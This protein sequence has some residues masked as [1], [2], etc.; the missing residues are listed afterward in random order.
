M[1]RL[2]R[3][4]ANVQ[5]KLALDRFI[6]G[7]A[8]ASV[9][10]AGAVWLTIIVDRV[11]RVRPP[12]WHMWFWAG[13]GVTL[14]AA[15]AYAILRRP[16]PHAAA[17]A[18]DQKLGLKEKISTALFV[19]PSTE[20]PFAAAA[21]RDAETTAER[22]SIDYRRLFPFRFPRPAVATVIIGALALWTL[23][24]KP[25]D[26]FGKEEQRKQ[27][28]QQQAK[29][30]DARR[31]I[32]RAIATV[33]AIPKAVANEEAIR[34]AKTELVNLKASGIKDPEQAKRSAAKALQDVNEA[35]KNKINNS[36]EFADARQQDRLLK[37]LQ[38]P[39]PGEGPIADAHN[40]MVK[41]DFANAIAQM[42][43]AIEKF[44]KMDAES[45]KK[46]SQQMQ[47]LAQAMQKMANDPQAQQQMQQQLQQM[48][49][50]QKQAQQAQQLMQQA[51]Q[52]DKQAQQ[53]LQ[54]MAQQ[55]MQQM[56]NGQGPNQQQQQ[57]IQQMMQQMQAMANNQQVAQQMQQAA[58]Q[59]AKAMQQQQQQQGQQGMQQQAQGQQGQQANQ[60]QQQGA[61]QQ[62]MQQ[63]MQAMRQQLQQMQAI[64][65]D[66]Q[67]M[68]AAQGQAAGAQAAAQDALNGGNP[69]GQNPGGGQWDMNGNIQGN[70]Q[71]G[72]WDG[73]ARPAGPNPGGIGAGDRTYKQQAPFTV[74]Q[75]V[76]QSQDD[77]KGKI[78]AS[79]FVKDSKP[80]K[81]DS[82]VTLKDVAA[83][84]QA[85]QTDEVD[86]ERISPQ[87][88]KAV[89]EYFSSMERE[90][91]PATQ[92]AR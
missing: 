29:V 37:Q 70:G 87:A 23:T 74:K 1:N 7:L 50:N 83:A 76:S 43:D 3:H 11:L 35:L 22:V 80:I 91:T 56:N 9:A 27:E 25:L 18:I 4:V 54:Q 32:D 84:A 90:T 41:G 16:S 46:A 69:G 42:E 40:S 13:L 34:L 6:A 2:D 21:V 81:G 14:V 85:E 48:G 30:E 59:M 8:W 62:G 66:A 68:A 44:D 12:A 17:V 58:Q 57:Q 64:A 52:G 71:E 75:E 65:G 78:L 36:Q 5:N 20:D 45:Q 82:K 53:Q 28:L 79:S 67:Q 61:G 92:P 49:M 55:M 15:L 86:T 19:R 77:E 26:L 31:V 72:E 60:Q 51:A 73:M 47:Q 89:R 88:Q 38:P 39:Q 10:F 33:E 24:M 63:G